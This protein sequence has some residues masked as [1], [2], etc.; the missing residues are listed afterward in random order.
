MRRIN[1]GP[2]INKVKGVV[3]QN[4]KP[5]SFPKYLE[6]QDKKSGDTYLCRVENPGQLN[7]ASV[8]YSIWEIQ[9]GKR[10]LSIEKRVV[11]NLVVSSFI[12]FYRAEVLIEEE[13]L[14]KLEGK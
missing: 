11:K 7:P 1:I 5:L 6:Y 4:K 14:K 10:A 8:L 9:P 12:A 3:F 2:F 13:F